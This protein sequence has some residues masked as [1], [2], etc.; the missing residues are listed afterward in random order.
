MDDELACR[1]PPGCGCRRRWGTWRWKKSGFFK[2]PASK[3]YSEHCLRKSWGS[4]NSKY[5]I[6]PPPSRH[7]F[8]PDWRHRA[9]PPF[10]RVVQKHLKREKSH[11]P[12][13][14]PETPRIRI[15]MNIFARI[16]IRNPGQMTDLRLTFIGLSNESLRQQFYNANMARQVR[17]QMTDL[18]LTFIDLWWP[19]NLA[20]LKICLMHIGWKLSTHAYRMWQHFFAV[21]DHMTSHDHDLTSYDLSW[22]FNLKNSYYYC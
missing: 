18:R 21:L 20:I 3:L 19:Q 15:R 1:G 11:F 6:S 8:G 13:Y 7:S 10:I 5:K 2:K 17:G 9:P 4:D 12:L 14:S 16:R 22:P